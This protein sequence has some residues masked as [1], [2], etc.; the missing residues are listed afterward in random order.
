MISQVI[1]WYWLAGCFEVFG[2]SFI[3]VESRL[4]IK[5]ITVYVQSEDLIRFVLADMVGFKTKKEQFHKKLLTNIYFDCFQNE[6][7]TMNAFLRSTCAGQTRSG[8]PTRHRWIRWTA[9]PEGFGIDIWKHEADHPNIKMRSEGITR[10]WKKFALKIWRKQEKLHAAQVN[11]AAFRLRDMLIPT[12]PLPPLKSLN[13]PINQ[14]LKGRWP[15][16]RSILDHARI[17]FGMFGIVC[18]VAC[19]VFRKVRADTVTRKIG[20]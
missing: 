5:G 18:S 2:S 17:L 8:S 15:Q 14:P 7:W 10:E 16:K 19:T 9:S 3:Q 1:S 4:G 11:K 6:W 20:G 12:V 13:Q